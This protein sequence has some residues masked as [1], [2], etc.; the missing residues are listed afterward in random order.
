MTARTEPH[1]VFLQVASLDM[2]RSHEKPAKD[3]ARTV[4]SASAGEWVAWGDVPVDSLVYVDGGRV[5][6]RRADERS[7]WAHAGGG[8]YFGT[9]QSWSAMYAG[10]RCKV[11][12][13]DLAA[14]QM[15]SN[16]K[17]LARAALS[18]DE[19]ALVGLT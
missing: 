12:A 1:V 9:K 13:R 6:M 14:D 4:Q 3:P 5:A 8:W 19:L 10:G 11:I 18:R 2:T 15:M 7:F 16:L 17:S